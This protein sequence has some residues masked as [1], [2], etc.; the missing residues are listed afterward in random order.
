ME[1]FG[2]VAKT[3]IL[4]TQ[5]IVIEKRQDSEKEQKCL[6]YKGFSKEK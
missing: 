2:N 4:Q 5:Q 3:A 6:F 1:K